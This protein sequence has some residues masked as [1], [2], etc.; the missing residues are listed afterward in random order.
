[1]T[2]VTNNRMTEITASSQNEQDFPD[3]IAATFT[4]KVLFI[5]GGTGF[6]G[7]VLLEKFLRRCS[8]IDTIY[9][10]VRNKKGKDPVQR[11]AE[12]FTSPLFDLVKKQRGGV[13]PLLKQV[14][15]IL[16]DVSLPDLGISKDDR[17]ELTERVQIIYHC[18]ATIRF[19][20]CLKKAVLLNTRGTKLMLQLAKECKQLLLF[21]HMSTSYCHLHVK[22]LLEKPYDPPADPHNIIKCVEWMDEDVIESITDKLL[23]NLPNTYA[24]TK[25]LSEGLVNEQMDK[26]PVVILRPSIVIPIWREP[27]PGW[28]DNINGPTGLLI[29]AGKGVIR[30]MFCD[31]SGYADYLPVDV[32]AN[33]VLVGTWNFI[34]NNDRTRRVFHLTSSAEIKVSWRELIELGRKIIQEKMPLNGVVWYPG[35]SMKKTRFAHNIAMFLFHLVPALFLDFILICT[36]H[37]PVLMRVQRRVNKGFEVFEYYANNT[38]EFSNENGLAIRAMLNPRE[39]QLYKIDGDGVDLEAYFTDCIHAA[40]LYILKETDDTIPA[41]RR[42]MKVMWWVDKISKTLI[43]ILFMWLLSKLFFSTLPIPSYFMHPK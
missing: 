18:A 43:I 40:R 7:K 23:G 28:T 2:Q 3:R 8:D 25:A 41:A 26:L 22:H 35:G 4:N 14:R 37:K 9:L 15:P 21:I 13:K 36:G 20:E 34:S 1:M 31:D 29:G 39:R 12:I 30:T 32:A 11:I 5:T 33:G 10:L 42:H 16:G 6:M 24:F 38:W 19:D 27:L 17:Q